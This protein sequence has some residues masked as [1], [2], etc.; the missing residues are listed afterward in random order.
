QR[1]A[2]SAENRTLK[3]LAVSELKTED[4]EGDRKVHLFK[5]GIDASLWMHSVCAVFQINH[6][7]AGK[8]PELQTLFFRLWT[9][10]KLPLHA[11]F[12]FDGLQHLPDKG[13]NIRSS[14]HWLTRD[15]QCML[16]SFGFPWTEAPSEAEAELAAMNVHGII[17]AVITEDS[18]IL[19]FGAPCI[20]QTVKND[21]DYLNVQVFTE[22]G[23]EHGCSLTRGDRLLIALLVGGDYDRGVPG[24]GIEIA[25]KVAL[26][27]KIGSM[28]LDAFLS[29]TPDEFSER[30]KELIEDL[31]T[32]LSTDPYN[33]LEHRYKAVA[34]SIPH[35][36]PQHAVVSKYVRALTS[37][38]AA[39]NATVA[40]PSDVSFYQP[41]LASLTDF[42]RQHLGWED[43]TIIEKMYG[44]I[45][46]GT[47]L[48]TLCKVSS[49]VFVGSC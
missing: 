2:L 8:S 21:K 16:E 23:L 48:R 17:D 29:M 28:M 36:F 39:G 44:G 31:H 10:L 25:H 7:G 14:H 46:E 49:T 35:G 34:D 9:L 12:I 45:W 37:F 11:V 26:H 30:A 19:I 5:V 43:D 20:I 27:S 15:F 40:L 18:D 33:F 3:E 13:R 22:D 24:C 38:S 42:C 6:A 4:V 32:L 1:V 47:Y 41:D